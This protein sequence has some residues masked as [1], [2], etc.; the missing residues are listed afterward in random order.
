MFNKLA[1]NF[2][3]LSPDFC[4]L[5][6]NTSWLLAERLLRMGLSLF[7]GVWIARYLGPDDYGLYSYALAFVFL[8]STLA[9]IGLDQIIIR[10]IVR[11]PDQKY[12]ILGTAFILKLLGSSIILPLT[13]GTSYLLRPDNPLVQLLV[14]TVSVGM[15]FRSLDVIEFWFWSQTNSKYSVLARNISIVLVSIGKV[16]AIQLNA[17]L[18]IFGTLF[19]LE[20]FLTSLGFVA[21]YYLQGNSLLS[22]RFTRKHAKSLMQEGWPL[23]LSSI[24]I[25][26]YMKTDQ[27]MLGQMLGDRS[28]GIYTAAS[29]ISEMWYFIPVAIANSLQPSIVKAKDLGEIKYFGRINKL[30][31]LMTS[32]SYIVAIIVSLL[33]SYI[34]NL[35]Y[36]GNYDESSAI[37]TVHIWA[38]LF[39]SLGLVRSLWTTTEGLVKLQ[40]SA[41]LIG[42]VVNIILNLIL[43]KSIGGLGAAIATV[44]SQAFAAYFANFFHP[45]TRKLFWSQ[46]MALLNPNPFAKE[47]LS[48]S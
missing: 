4:R 14:A 31:K 26:I 29:K 21:F 40:F 45:A 2:R 8:F 46:T 44:I 35:L 19:S 22:W 9:T 39:V 28:V 20:L 34:I 30:L 42:A 41:S 3:K 13:V 48:I 11:Q 24:V 47:K 23:M 33:S 5:V 16:V 15:V 25:L 18:V 37:L 7:V 43:I 12:E 36:G 10:D 6:S 1:L 27:I 32:L 38:G 17:P